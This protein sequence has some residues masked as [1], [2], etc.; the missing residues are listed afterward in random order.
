MSQLLPLESVFDNGY[1]EL[2]PSSGDIATFSFTG[3]VCLIREVEQRLREDAE[4]AVA[5]IREALAADYV[6]GNLETP[7]AA[8][9]D[10]DPI[11]GF[12]NS[13]PAL[14]K[15]LISL[16][17]D[18]FTI[19]NNH[20]MDCGADGLNETL[21]F[22][23]QNNIE[24]FGAGENLQNARQPLIVE[25]NNI[26]IGLLGYSQPELDAAET[27]RAG[28][29]PL[30]KQAILEDI[31]NLK[32]QVDNVVLVLHEGYEFQNYPRLDFLNLC[33]ELAQSGVDL[34]CGHHPHVMHGME[35]VGNC[36]ILY[37]LGNFWFDLSY[38]RRIPQT[39]N[40]T[41]AHVSFDQNGPVVLKL[42]P[43]IMDDESRLHVAQGETRKNILQHLKDISA[44]LQNTEAIREQNAI[45]AANVMRAILG[46]V[47]N[48]G[49]A[50]DK[51]GFEKFVE[52][53]IRRD[54]YLKTFFDYAK[55]I[56]EYKSTF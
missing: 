49:K 21:A 2:R 6:V 33:R 46:N 27:Q 25:R 28:I 30:R 13:D 37:S 14:A 9:S 8:T 56:G 48:L 47:Y 34:I 41:I 22:L 12:L 55:L 18:A 29:S 42:T 16:G 50:N 39:R 45:S 5:G 51:A 4:S 23:N 53:Q 31:A 52:H 36:L 26:K 20:T 35:T 40:S 11:R 24:H 32:P 17:F 43:T 19:A 15:V 1:Q 10:L 44:V 7:L 3:D 54:P 38:H